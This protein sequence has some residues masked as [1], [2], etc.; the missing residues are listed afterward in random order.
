MSQFD[1]PITK[2][3]WN[4]GG[5]P[6]KKEKWSASSFWPT[7]IGEKGRTLGK[8]YGIKPG[9]YWEHPWG[10]H[11][12]PIGNLMGTKEKWME[13]ESW[14]NKKKWDLKKSEVLLRT[15]WK[16]QLKTW[17]TFWEHIGNKQPQKKNFPPLAL[18]PSNWL[19][20]NFLCTCCPYEFTLLFVFCTCCPMNLWIYFDTSQHPHPLSPFACCTLKDYYIL[21]ARILCILSRHVG[22]I[23]G[24][25]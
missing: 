2:K 8:T 17:G 24:M 18:W 20:F 13:V 9:C 23:L 3:Y 21:V 5:S 10:T 1:W 4:Y 22:L 16:A 15:S 25:E 6:K 19:I 12:E 7:Y 14:S 11:W